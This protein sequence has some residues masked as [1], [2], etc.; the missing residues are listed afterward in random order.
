MVLH[1]DT[2]F[3]I[4]CVQA[5]SEANLNLATWI[6]RG[7]SFVVSAMAW[8]EWLCGPLTKG[9]EDRVR[10]IVDQIRLVDEPTAVLGAQLF[11]AT[12]RRS[13]SQP[14]CL[15]AA[16]AILDGAPIATR[17]KSDFALFVP[18]GLL[19]V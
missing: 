14:D 13:R 19:L 3:L 5:D 15:I 16:A 18:H 10:S 11:N 9:E 8:H 4:D 17:N 2:N 1:L 7:D 6:L 12:N